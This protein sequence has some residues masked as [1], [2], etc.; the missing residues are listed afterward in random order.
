MYHFGFVIA[1]VVTVAVYDVL[2][3]AVTMPLVAT[4]D[5]IF[6]VILAIV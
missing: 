6:A 5:N 3:V 4:I 1:D 2:D